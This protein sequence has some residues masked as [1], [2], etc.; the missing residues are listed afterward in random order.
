[1]MMTTTPANFNSEIHRVDFLAPYAEPQANAESFFDLGTRPVESLDGPWHFAIDPFDTCL[2]ARWF[3]EKYADQAGRPCPTD[4]SFDEWEEVPVPSCWNVLKP[5]WKWFEGSGVYVRNLDFHPGESGER[6]FLAFAG[7]AYAAYVF[8]NGDYL[9]WHRGGSTPFRFEVT[10]KLK[11]RNR[12][13]VVVRNAREVENVPTNNFDWFNYG[14]LH[15]GVGLVRLPATFVKAASVTLVPDG[16]FSTVAVSVTVDGAERDGQ[17][18]VEIPELGFA[19]SLTVAGGVGSAEFDVTPQLWSPDNPKLYDVVIRY[20]VDEWSDRIGFREIRV[21][22][23]EVL[24]N[25]VPVFLRG[26]CSHEESDLHG[27]SLTD[28]EI[29]ETFRIAKEMGCDFM[30]L[31]H[32][33]HSRATSRIADEVG[34]MLWEEVPVYWAI[35]FD[36][37][38]TLNDADNQLRELILRD[39]NR[40]SVIIWSVGNENAD[41]DARLA[42]MS[43]LADTC[44]DLDPT[45]LVSAACLVNPVIPAISDRLVDKLDV[46]GLNEYYGWYD[47]DFDKLPALFANSHPSKPVIITEFGADATPD[48]RGDAD[49]LYTEDHQLQIYQRQ[50]EVLSTIDYIK[51]ATP[52]IFYDFRCPRRTHV[53][54]GYYNRKGLLSPDKTHRKLAFTAM[55]NWYQSM[56]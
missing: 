18:R 11:A 27:R 50:I 54:Q 33:P 49:E 26:V 19:G 41:T 53:L 3:E 30:R 52:W 44:H 1:M 45:R 32:Y 23:N 31:A 17:A 21:D 4:F 46:I 55:Q 48:L 20:G 37:P 12:L 43:H 35:M 24:L 47:P 29:R 42:F 13:V 34:V 28:E 6:V 8:L 22:G 9:G 15:R 56:M 2:R 5:E 38:S 10:G 40:A 14:G 25:G 7:A 39:R 51:G 36:S 16:S